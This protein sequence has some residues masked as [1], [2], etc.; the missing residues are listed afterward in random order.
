MGEKVLMVFIKL[1]ALCVRKTSQFSI[2]EYDLTKHEQ[3]ETH[4]L[5]SKT[6]ASSS[7]IKQLFKRNDKS[8]SLVAEVCVGWK[9]YV[10]VYAYIFKY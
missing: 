7:S 9:W 4:K 8:A 1:G 2:E 6:V 5:I 10:H 3:T